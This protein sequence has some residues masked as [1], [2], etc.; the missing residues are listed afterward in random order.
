MGKRKNSTEQIIPLILIVAIIAIVALFMISPAG[1]F[2]TL[3]KGTHLPGDSLTLFGPKYY[4][5]I[6]SNANVTWQDICENNYTKTLE[7]LDPD[8]EFVHCGITGEEFVLLADKHE[9]GVKAAPKGEHWYMV[10]GYAPDEDDPEAPEN[11]RFFFISFNGPN[12]PLLE[13]EMAMQVYKNA[14]KKYLEH[15]PGA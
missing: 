5:S 3:S 4:E 7:L 2:R 11:Y 15:M 9:A 8:N 12:S 14:K 6:I 13:D 1:L 10:F